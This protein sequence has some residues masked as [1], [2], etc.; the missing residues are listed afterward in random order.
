ML[1]LAKAVMNQRQAE[2]TYG[3]AEDELTPTLGW[4]LAGLRKQWNAR[5]DLVAPWWAE[6]SKEAYNSGSDALA[7]GLD[8]WSTSRK[9]KRAGKTIGFPKF[10]TA[11]S[12][13][14][15][16]F[17]TGTIRV[18]T[19]RHHVT[20]PRLGRIHTCESTRK[21]ARRIEAGTARIL[22]ATL[23][24]D[25]AGRWHVAFQ[26]LVHRA[27]EVPGHVGAGESVVGVDVGMKADPLI[28]VATP[29]R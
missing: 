26:V 11:R 9:G 14:S 1:A 28:V 3:I 22:S 16:R 13:R 4:S 21:L 8:A 10:K 27:V 6:N 19:D 20:L 23:S 17:T 7:R 29:A 18:E 25:S 2:R 12:R 15:V 5:K 24:E